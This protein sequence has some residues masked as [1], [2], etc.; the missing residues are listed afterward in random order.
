MIK[1]WFVGILRMD[2]L[3]KGIPKCMDLLYRQG[4]CEGVIAYVIQQ[5]LLKLRFGVL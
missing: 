3:T 5:I 1:E 4:R 2:T